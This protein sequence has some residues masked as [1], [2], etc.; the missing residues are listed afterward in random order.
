MD[1]VVKV[2]AEVVR[3]CGSI[4]VVVFCAGDVFPHKGEAQVLT[5][6]RL[7][8]CGVKTATV[9]GA[10]RKRHMANYFARDGLRES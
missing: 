2:H 8:F 9:V 6:M 10:I 5:R 3:S 7:R 4:A 1:A